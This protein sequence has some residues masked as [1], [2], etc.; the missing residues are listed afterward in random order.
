MSLPPSL[1]Q[2]VLLPHL[3]QGGRATIL[4]EEWHTVDAV[5]HLDW[6]LQQ[7]G[8][9]QQVTLFWNANNTFGFERIDWRR[10]AQAAIITTVSRYMKHLMWGLGVD[11]LVIPNGLAADAFMPPASRDV[12]AFYAQVPG[13]TV[14]SK[15]AR[16][17]PDKRWRL[18]IAIV[19]AMRQA[20]WQPLLIARGG[21]EA[22]GAEVLATAAAQGLRVVERAMP[23]PG[24]RG[25]LH[26][27][28]DVHEADIVSL[29]SP[30]DPASR[31]LLFHC[32]HAVLANSGREP[33][34]LVGLETMAAGGV[35]C[36]GCSGEDYAIPGRNALVLE[37]N[38]PQEFLGL[39]AALRADP[40]REQALR[41]A[42]RTTAQQYRWSEILRCVLLPRLHCP[43]TP[44]RVLQNARVA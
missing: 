23:R 9:R 41:R 31:Q 39:Y 26:A 43:A 24:V 34:G 5:L 19:G 20:G 33:F 30:V 27:L 22:H 15:V 4:A 32:S 10:L 14:V 38:D 1:C 13:R 6:L 42:G 7:A 18:A 17:D 44:G 37:T 11:P 35:A 25:L 29:R 28:E 21:V 40:A 8:L 12:A 36:T 3:H 2:D 16:W